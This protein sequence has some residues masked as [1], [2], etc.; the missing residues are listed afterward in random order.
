VKAA[1][2]KHFSL[3][4]EAQAHQSHNYAPVHGHGHEDDGSYNPERYENEAYWH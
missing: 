1:K 3:V 2:A 4:H